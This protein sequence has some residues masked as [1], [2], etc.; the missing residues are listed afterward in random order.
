MSPIPW[1][2]LTR[3]QDSFGSYSKSRPGT[4]GDPGSLGQI[5]GTLILIECTR[6]QAKPSWMSASSLRNIIAKVWKQSVLFKVDFDV[7]SDETFLDHDQIVCPY[8]FT[9]N[10]LTCNRPS[11]EFYL[12][13]GKVFFIL[14]RV[15]E[16]VKSM[17]NFRKGTTAKTRGNRSHG[18]NGIGVV[19]GLLD[20]YL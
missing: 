2:E 5:I 14:Q 8:W 17:G 1:G 19:S 4:P 16:I 10:S 7:E 13:E 6:R 9:G 15:L 18:L 20:I 12:W 11:L 3:W